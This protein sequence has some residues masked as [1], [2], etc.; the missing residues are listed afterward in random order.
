MPAVVMQVIKAG[1]HPNADTLYVYEMLSA[2]NASTPIVANSTTIYEVGDHAI[3][4]TLG[5]KLKA[6]N[7][8]I[9]ETKI[10]GIVSCGMALGKSDL[11]IGTDLTD[12]YCLPVYHVSWPDIE[13]LFNVYDGLAKFGNLRPVTYAAKIK[14]DGQCG[15]V[16][17][18]P[19]GDVLAQTRT[20]IVT[21]NNDV[22]GFAAWVEQNREYF[23]NLKTAETIIVFGEWC[24]PGVKKGCAVAKIPEKIFCV[25]AIQYGTRLDINPYTIGDFLPENKSIFSLPFYK[26][27]IVLHYE[28]REVLQ[29]SVDELNGWVREVEK[30][31][32]FIKSLFGI[33][34]IGEGLVFY[35]IPTM[36][37]V[38]SPLMVEREL[39]KELVFKAKGEEHK[40]VKVK[41]PVQIDPETAKNAAE[42]AEL[43]VTIPRLEQIAGKLGDFDMK[44]TG[45]FIKQF[46]ADVIKESKA[47][48]A[49]SKL[50][51]KDVAGQVSAKCREWWISK[52]K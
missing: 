40:V 19:N 45:E 36:S 2:D 15:A 33:E 18:H 31:D 4:A 35:P 3:V 50:D 39:Y 5:S 17:I 46:T 43:F 42:F 26:E 47:E 23:S 48:L 21:K 32:P 25:F 16:Q 7:L 8:Y 49:A 14:I 13:S 1:K 11:P 34:G 20:Q 29:K 27:P 30:C 44:K 10:R 24:G 22:C 51:W 41:S 38:E 12:Q 9:E 37:S 28:D 6:D 52:C